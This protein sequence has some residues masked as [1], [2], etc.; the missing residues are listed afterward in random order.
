[1]WREKEQQEHLRWDTGISGLCISHLGYQWH[2]MR[3]KLNLY[4]SYPQHNTSLQKTTHNH[5][6]KIAGRV[7]FQLSLRGYHCWTNHRNSTCKIY[8]KISWPL[9]RTFKIWLAI[10]NDFD[11]FIYSKQN[12]AAGLRQI[13][14]KKLDIMSQL[15]YEWQDLYSKIQQWKQHNQVDIKKHEITMKNN[16]T[17]ILMGKMYF[18]KNIQVLKENLASLVE[19]D[20]KLGSDTQS[21]TIQ[22]DLASLNPNSDG[23]L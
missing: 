21:V 16:L 7:R 8:D 18:S 3:F 20:R 12:Y 19:T 22:S 14:K 9:H 1:M 4:T 5:V 13:L 23:R 15:K 2:H 10:A 6:N 11:P 17:V